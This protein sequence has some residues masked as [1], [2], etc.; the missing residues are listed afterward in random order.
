MQN[1]VNFR[2][3]YSKVPETKVLESQITKRTLS[4]VREA[5]GID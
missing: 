3:V 5:Q 2:A 4:P 1:I